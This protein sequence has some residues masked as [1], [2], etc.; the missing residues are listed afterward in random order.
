MKWIVFLSHKSPTNNKMNSTL[1]EIMKYKLL[2][3]K[4]SRQQ[5]NVIYD[6]MDFEGYDEKDAK[7]KKSGFITDVMNWYVR[8]LDKDCLKAARKEEINLDELRSLNFAVNDAEETLTAS[9]G[10]GIIASIQLKKAKYTML[11]R[12]K[13]YKKLEYIVSQRQKKNGENFFTYHVARKTPSWG[14]NEDMKGQMKDWRL[15]KKQGILT[16]NTQNNREFMI[17]GKKWYT[18]VIQ[19]VD[20]EKNNIDPLGFGVG[21]VVSGMIYWF[22]SKQ[23]R[24]SVI[25]YV[26]K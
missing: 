18:M 14:N 4:N 17:S 1:K 16:I 20:L 15:Q 10:S 9:T 13:Q 6:N 5:M 11:S 3:L 26:M 19:D 8:N 21:F 25:S 12:Q 2:L 24:D 23:N 7:K 22:S